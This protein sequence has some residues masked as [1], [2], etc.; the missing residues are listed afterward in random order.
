M[1]APDTKVQASP[2]RCRLYATLSQNIQNICLVFV[3]LGSVKE[4]SRNTGSGYLP[5]GDGKVP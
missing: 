3:G 5:D 2:D 1:R 4:S